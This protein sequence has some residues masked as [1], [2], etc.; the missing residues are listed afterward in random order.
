MA[1]RR[2]LTDARRSPAPRTT[3]SAPSSPSNTAASAPAAAAAAA[4][5]PG[6]CTPAALLPSPL[7]QKHLLKKKF[8]HWPAINYVNLIKIC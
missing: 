5:A 2:E 1:S 6:A 3:P 8:V 7:D 4:G